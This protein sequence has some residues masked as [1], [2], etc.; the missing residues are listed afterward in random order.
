MET[1]LILRLFAA[2]PFNRNAKQIKPRPH[3]LALRQLF[4]ISFNLH[5]RHFTRPGWTNAVQAKLF[6]PGRI[7]NL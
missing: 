2:N 7:L 1:P 4:T 6:W 3:L 5:A